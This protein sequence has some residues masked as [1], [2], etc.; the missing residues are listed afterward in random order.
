MRISERAS[1][2]VSD[3]ICRSEIEAG[4]ERCHSED[5]ISHMKS[6]NLN[7]SLHQI[8]RPDNP[9]SHSSF[10]RIWGI[11]LMLLSAVFFAAINFC[12]KYL[13]V[14]GYPAFQQ[15]FLRGFYYILFGAPALYLTGGSYYTLSKGEL[16]FVKYRTFVVTM[17]SSTLT[18]VLGFMSA[19]TANVLFYTYP[20]FTPLVSR[21]VL[22]EKY[23]LINLFALIIC[24]AGLMFLLQPAFLFGVQ[25]PLK[26]I[27]LCSFIWGLLPYFLLP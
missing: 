19:S 23:K 7:F 24:F 18:V 5:Y 2:S 16:L 13:Y 21:I 27:L 6:H 20:V 17:V 14:L 3:S 22:K 9:S 10:R 8:N 11:S 12:V 4:R 25:I 15:L 1:V 26:T